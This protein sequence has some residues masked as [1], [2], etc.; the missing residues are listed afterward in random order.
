MSRHAWGNLLAGV[1]F[2]IVAIIDFARDSSGI[3]VVF[4]VFAAVF[5]SLGPSRRTAPRDG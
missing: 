5:V 4:L 3:G 2:F 1:L